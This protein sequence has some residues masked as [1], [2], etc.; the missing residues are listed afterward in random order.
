M[1]SN[2]DVASRNRLLAALVP[3][4]LRLLLPSLKVAPLEAKRVIER[5]HQ[6]IDYVYFVLRGLVSVVG[7]ALPNHRIEMA[8]VGCEGM[9]GLAVVLGDDQ[10]ANEVIVQSAGVAVRL[11]ADA[12]RSF[13]IESRSLTTSL[14]HYVHV[15]MMQ[16]SQTALAN[17]RGVLEERL[18]R[19]LMMWRDRLDDDNLV[20]TA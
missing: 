7:T 3:S 14:M 18:A 15:F 19:W 12:L 6:P 4:D 5:A 13:M 20:I 16:A 2:F 8:M 17:G 1:F 10:S 11:P 9:T